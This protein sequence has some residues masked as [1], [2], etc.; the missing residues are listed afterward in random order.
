MSCRD[1]EQKGEREILAR[2]RSR[3][4]GDMPRTEHDATYEVEPLLLQPVHDDL[5]ELVRDIFSVGFLALNIELI[6]PSLI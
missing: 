3:K 1:T 5:E 4:R 2:A 6:N